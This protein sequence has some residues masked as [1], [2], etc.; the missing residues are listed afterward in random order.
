MPI[1]QFAQ[2]LISTFSTA[3]GE[4][5]L[6]PATGGVFTVEICHIDIAAEAEAEAE[7]AGAQE[8]RGEEGDAQ[9]E[10][11]KEREMRVEKRVLWDRKVEGGFPETKELKRRVRDVIQPGRDLGHVDGKK[12]A[13]TAATGMATRTDGGGEQMRGDDPLDSKC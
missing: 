10:R 1:I 5:S 13:T 11:Q 6:I 12:G 8:D 4:V 3:L 2:E 7:R 9:A